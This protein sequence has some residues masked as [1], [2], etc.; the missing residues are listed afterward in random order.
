MSDLL[1]A[2]ASALGVPEPLVERAAEARASAAGVSVDEILTAWAGGEAAPSATE[3]PAPEPEPEAEAPPTDEEAEPEEEPAH[4]EPAPSPEPAAAPAAAAVA[5]RAP[6]PEQV[7][8]SQ[9]ATVPVVVT[10][11]TAGIKERTAFA[12]P[13]WLTAVLVAAPVFA[14]FALG[15]SATGQCGE[16]TELAMEVVTGDIINC[17]GSEFTGQ[18]IADGVTDFIAMGE[19][20]YT[21][22]AVVGVN[23]AGCHAPD[24]GGVGAMP[25]LTGVLTTFRSCV[26][27]AEWVEKGAPGFQAEGRSTYGDTNRPVNAMPSHARLT[28][29]ELAA[30]SAYERIRFGGGDREEVLVACGLAD[31]PDD[32]EDVEGDDAITESGEDME[33]SADQSG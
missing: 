6:A 26:D 11:P 22:A 8:P 18:V 12:I 3:E 27:H 30:V 5:E 14:L 16:A 10:V 24:G 25:A 33:A 31:P 2:A 9:V 29:E 7:T 23:C 15:G 4:T 17:D 1:S 20:I 28:E 19:Q 32:T 21:G 13:K